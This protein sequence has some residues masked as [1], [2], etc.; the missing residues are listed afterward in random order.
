MPEQNQRIK[1]VRRKLNA[2]TTEFNNKNVL[3]VDDSIVRGT[4]S[5]QIIEMARDAGA[6]KVYMASA[7]PPI[8]YPNVYGIDMPAS[9]EF[10]AGG[11]NIE[12]ITKLIN[13]DKLI[14]QDLKDLIEAV[15]DPNINTQKFDSSC[16]DGKYVTGNVTEEYLEELDHLRNDSAKKKY[17]STDLSDDVMVY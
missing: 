4:T 5:K 2:I 11:R 1:S 14:Y 6:K 10:A 3:L 9:H 15:K 16:F 13:A 7:A 17:S 8:K 12:E